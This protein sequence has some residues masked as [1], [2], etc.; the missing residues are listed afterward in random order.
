MERVQTDNKNSGSAVVFWCITAA[1]MLTIFLL[2]SFSG[3][4]LP[5]LPVNF[6][7]VVH[8]L[9]YVPLSFFIYS[10]LKRSGF[11]KYVFV[12]AFLFASLYG[13]SDEFHQSFVPGRDAAVGDLFADFLGAFLGCLG[14]SFS[15]T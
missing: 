10:A 9:I 8:A 12:T 6:D 13:V 14:G 11:R 2:S 3:A 1:Y 5:H 7:K 15:R 4:R